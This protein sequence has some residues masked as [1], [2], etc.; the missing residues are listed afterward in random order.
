MSGLLPTGTVTLLLAD[1]EGSTLLW[2]NQPDD[3]AIAIAQLN[4]HGDRSHRGTRRCATRRSKVKATASWPRSRRPATRSPVRWRCNG[5]RSR[6]SCYE[7]GVHTGEIQLRDE[8]NYAGPTINRTAR[9][10]DLAHGGQTVLSGATEPLIVD[11]LPD[12]AW[13]TDLGHTPRCA[14]CSA[15]NGW[16]SCATQIF[17]TSL[18]PLRIPKT[19]AVHNLPTRA[20]QLHRTRRPAH[21]G[22]VATGTQPPGDADQR[23]RRRQDYRLATQVA[24]RIAGECGDGLWYVDLALITHPDVVPVTVARALGLPDQPGRS[25]KGKPESLGRRPSDVGGAR[26]LVEHLLDA[27]ATLI[28]D[29]LGACPGLTLLATSRGTD[30]RREVRWPG[31]YRRSHLATKPS[32]CSPDRARLAQTDFK[33]TGA[34]RPKP[35][36]RSAVVWMAC[37]LRSELAAAR[38]RA[39]SLEEI[40][41]SLHDRLPPVDWRIAAPQYAV[42]KLC[43][44]RSTG[45]HALLTE[46]ER[47]LFRRL[48]VFVRGVRPRQRS[49]RLPA[50]MGWS[51]T[52]F[53]I[54][55]AC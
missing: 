46:T 37:R 26:Q 6:R 16:C 39:L 36:A 52:R 43:G 50:L 45:R 51:A 41:D 23:R 14:I 27:C 9:L 20:D 19:A 3:M 40:V 13:L 5:R 21:R 10:R 1:V 22:P 55:S 18:P 53:S 2:D 29:L 30:R 15:P 44:R 33:M 12:D 28:V 48:S 7:S 47:I 34:R 8:G 31:E 17:V 35:W 4:R 32:S 11:R 42:N 38:V 24:A 25:T 54:S 49:R